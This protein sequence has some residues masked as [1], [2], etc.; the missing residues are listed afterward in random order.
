M[1]P[2]EV[3]PFGLS[4]EESLA[5]AR[6]AAASL[7]AQGEP[8]LLDDSGSHPIWRVDEMVIRLE[9]Y[10]YPGEIKQ[11]LAM[12]SWL[13]SVGIPF[14]RPA[15]ELPI[16]TETCLASAWD[17][18]DP[19]GDVDLEALGA[20]MARFHDLP[21]TTCPEPAWPPDRLR[22]ALSGP[23]V[24]LTGAAVSY[25]TWAADLLDAWSEDVGWRSLHRNATHGD[26]W[27]K[28]VIPAGPGAVVLCDPDFL[29]ARPPASDLST[30]TRE[31]DAGAMQALK[32]GYGELPARELLA[33][34]HALVIAN[35]A[36]YVIERRTD[37][38]EGRDELAR[39]VFDLASTR[40]D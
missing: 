8:T 19:A 4:G 18:V 7:G 16:V 36:A 37:G 12:A 10:E 30:L 27:L 39:Y 1:D 26:L 17:Y 29:G 28:N 31:L 5:A 21:A 23:A 34:G 2:A 6:Q 14:V 35:W 9:V 33:V 32:A 25:L 11:R 40:P 22:A 20:A 38:L 3:P 15:H 24:P 13:C